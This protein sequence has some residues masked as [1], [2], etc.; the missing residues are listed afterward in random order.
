MKKAPATFPRSPDPSSLTLVIVVPRFRCAVMTY[1][2]ITVEVPPA[3]DAR[4]PGAG[5]L[6]TYKSSASLDTVQAYSVLHTVRYIP[7]SWCREPLHE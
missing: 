4:A 7:S 5:P 2:S 6:R 3:R 1:Y